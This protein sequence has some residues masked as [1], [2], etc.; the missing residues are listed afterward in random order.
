MQT[1]NTRTGGTLYWLALLS[2]SAM[3]FPDNVRTNLYLDFGQVLDGEIWRIISGH[4][5]HLSWTHWLMNMLGLVLL[6]QLY[7]EHFSNWR[8]LA[9]TLF[10]MLSVSAGLLIFSETLKWYGGLSGVLVGL[11]YI[12][13]LRDYWRR[14]IFNGLA[15]L[16][17]SL[18]ILTQQLSGERIEGLSHGLVV[19]ARAH[20]FG[21]LAGLVW[22]V[23]SMSIRRLKSQLTDKKMRTKKYR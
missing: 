2:A 23:I 22:I 17:I 10:I 21:A 9:P 6:Q 5:S 18:Y 11:F 3:L 16:G 1:V 13:A 19:A 8:W 15:L 7:G 14:R 20:L 4:F 12:A